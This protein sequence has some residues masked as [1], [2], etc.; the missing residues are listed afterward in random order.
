MYFCV[1]IRRLSLSWLADECRP[2]QGCYSEHTAHVKKVKSSEISKRPT[3]RQNHDSSWLFSSQWQ[4][5]RSQNRH[6]ECVASSAV[7]LTRM[8]TWFFSCV[9]ECC[10]ASQR[11]PGWSIPSSADRQRVHAVHAINHTLPACHAYV[12]IDVITHLSPDCADLL[13]PLTNR[14]SVA[15]SADTERRWYVIVPHQHRQSQR[16]TRSVRP[17]IPRREPTTHFNV[18]FL[19]ANAGLLAVI[20]W[21]GSAGH[22]VLPPSFFCQPFCI[23]CFFHMHVL[24]YCNT[25]GWTWWD[26]SLILRTYSFSAFDTVGWVIWPIKTRPWYD[27]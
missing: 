18:K 20:Y 12:I 6:Q 4:R 25:V 14:Q 27:P 3:A 24:Y 9:W 21:D 2:H 5:L 11:H 13:S 22:S 8:C 15:A 17:T 16:R 7:C 23:L 10:E 26:W 1:V 19:V